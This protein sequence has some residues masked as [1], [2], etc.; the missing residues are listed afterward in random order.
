[1]Q[2]HLDCLVNEFDGRWAVPRAVAKHYYNEVYR[3]KGGLNNANAEVMGGA[4]AIRAVRKVAWHAGRH[5]GEEASDRAVMDCALT[6]VA[7]LLARKAAVAPLA[8]DE[9]FENVGRF[10]L[11]TIIQIKVGAAQDT[12]CA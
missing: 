7:D 3:N 1:Y 2:E 6:E 9:V 11:A 5:E 8:A 12:M 10:A 4:A